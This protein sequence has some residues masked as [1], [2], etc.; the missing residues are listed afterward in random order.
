MVESPSLDRSLLVMLFTAGMTVQDCKK[1]N[2]VSFKDHIQV[3]RRINT[4]YM[5]LFAVIK[6]LL[7]C[8]NPETTLS[9]EEPKLCKILEENELCLIYIEMTILK[10]PLERLEYIRATRNHWMI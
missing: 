3:P 4:L 6:A 10:E 1:K 8:G 9:I 7:P 2:T 5:E